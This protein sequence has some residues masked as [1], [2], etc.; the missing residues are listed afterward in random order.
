MFYRDLFFVCFCQ[1]CCSSDNV[2]ICTCYSVECASTDGF[3][4]IRYC[5]TCHKLKH[6]VGSSHIFHATVPSV[7]SS[8]VELQG[9]L[10][11]AIVRCAFCVVQITL[12]LS[13]RFC[14]FLLGLYCFSWLAYG[15]DTVFM[16][17]PVFW[18]LL[19]HYSCL[20]IVVNVLLRQTVYS[21]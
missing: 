15:G 1:N 14:F 13:N 16:S 18:C 12:G 21:C 10:V 3:R 8:D 4:P 11:D 20:D 9:Y 17:M 7:W 5:A 6:I 2:A 19:E